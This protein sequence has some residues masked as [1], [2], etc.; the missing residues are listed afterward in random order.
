LKFLITGSKGLIGS[1]DVKYF[2]KKGHK[3]IGIDNN[4]RCF[5]GEKGDTIWNL[6]NLK[7]QFLNYEHNDIDIRNREAILRLYK[8]TRPDVTIHCAAQPSHDLAAKIPFDDFDTNA[9]RTINLLESSRRHTP[10]SPFL[11]MSTN[12]V[13]GDVPNELELIEKDFRW[14]YTD[15]KYYAEVI[16]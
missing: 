12:K 7:K 11:F 15:P 8:E 10:E 14:E 4:L 2:S 16:I 1:E 3:I 13:Y 6:N 5:F 9:V